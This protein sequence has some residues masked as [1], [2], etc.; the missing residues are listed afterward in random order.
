MKAHLQRIAAPKSW[1][2][3][4]KAKKYVERPRPSGHSMSHSIPLTVVIR[5]LLKFAKTSKEVKY[6]LQQGSV[7]VNGRKET[8]MKR[9][10]GLMDIIE[11]AG[12]GKAYCV[13]LD[14]AGKISLAEQKDKQGLLGRISGKTTLKGAR[15]QLNLS[16]GMNLIAAKDLYKTG[17][18]ILI[19]PNGEIK[20]HFPIEKG[21]L[22]YLV[23][24]K[25]VGS[26]VSIDDI[27]DKVLIFRKD[28][29]E[30]E[31]PARFA[32]I[33]GRDKP[34]IDVP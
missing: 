22:A 26:V 9:A 25:H 23:G 14:K 12:L 24:G 7:M 6:I 2:I 3:N 10:V 21:A 17:D 15:M 34:V 8:R 19:G 28:G 4:R 18:S 29:Q 27:K 33:I 5:D 11:F 32:F 30:F 31:T 20:D 16:G 1:V 13:I